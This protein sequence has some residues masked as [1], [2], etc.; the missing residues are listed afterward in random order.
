MKII[1]QR[2]WNIQIKIQF[3]NGL[4]IF[5]C[6]PSWTEFMKIALKFH[7]FYDDFWATGSV[8]K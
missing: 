7:I 3:D 5:N 1:F 8:T 4:T 6:E 2:F